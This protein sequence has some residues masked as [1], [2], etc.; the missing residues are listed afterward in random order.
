MLAAK[1]EQAEFTR[2]REREEE[3]ENEIGGRE[4]NIQMYEC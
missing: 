1:S 3:R 2:E 4:D